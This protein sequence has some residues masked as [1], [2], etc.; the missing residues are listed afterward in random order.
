MEKAN[1]TG[2]VIYGKY[3]NF[4]EYEYRGKKGYLTFSV[5]LRKPTTEL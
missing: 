4:V 2:F 5:V 1:K 3:S